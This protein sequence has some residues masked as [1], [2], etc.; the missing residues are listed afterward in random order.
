MRPSP[1][2]ALAAAGVAASAAAPR[3]SATPRLVRTVRGLPPYGRGLALTPDGTTAFVVG[4]LLGT[5]CRVRLS[6]GAVVGP[7]PRTD[8]AAARGDPMR[9]IGASAAVTP[10]GE[11]LFAAADLGGRLFVL[12]GA[13]CELAGA[14][15][16][17]AG[18]GNAR[19]AQAVALS[20]DGGTLFVGCSGG[21]VHLL[22]APAVTAAARRGEPVAPPPRA[23][24][25]SEGLLVRAAA[26]AL[27]GRGALAA[28]CSSGRWALW[29]A[30]LQDGA[31]LIA[32]EQ[33]PC[34]AAR[35]L[36]FA[37]GGRALVAGGSDDIRFGTYDG[38]L[39][40][41]V[42]PA[43]VPELAAAGGADP[44]LEAW[45]G[46]PTDAAPPAP[47]SIRQGEVVALATTADGSRVFAANSAGLAGE[48]RPGAGEQAL[49]PLPEP[50]EDAARES[51]QEAP[52]LH[53]L[54]I[55]AAGRTLVG[56]REAADGSTSELLIWA[57]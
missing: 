39:C 51:W 10:D 52:Q 44:E 48:W 24:L 30:P 25:R 32:T 7:P 28:L 33:L 5:V 47:T 16:L 9:G 19:D 56:L 45:E 14:L 43:G 57:L 41:W 2:A 49:V 1:A 20:A 8:A 21:E 42:L 15:R 37:A 11:T 23:V 46:P 36:A 54:T 40:R 12:N 31:T 3:A 22:D 38:V 17:E 50:A 35:A 4:P 6:D 34:G 55:D 13:D 27:S 53:A 29:R 26:L 18:A